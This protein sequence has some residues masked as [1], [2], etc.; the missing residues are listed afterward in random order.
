MDSIAIENRVFVRIA[1]AAFVRT[2]IIVALLIKSQKHDIFVRTVVMIAVLIKSKKKKHFYKDCD[3][4]CSPIKTQ[5]NSIFVRTAIM[6]AEH[7]Y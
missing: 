1:I 7:I 3:H 2:A 4:D 5:K 6:I